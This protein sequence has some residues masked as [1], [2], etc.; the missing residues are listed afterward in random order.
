MAKDSGEEA[1]AG[2]AVACISI[3]ITLPMWFALLFG[4]LDRIEAPTWM[5][6]C[7]FAYMPS[8]WIAVALQKVLALK[9]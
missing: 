4:I 7:F 3:F 1:A 2:C 9:T 8:T 5:W 6:S